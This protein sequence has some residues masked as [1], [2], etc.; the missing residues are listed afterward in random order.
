MEVGVVGM[1][2]KKKGRI[3]QTNIHKTKCTLGNTLK[4]K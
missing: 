3:M 1:G 2:C 4:K